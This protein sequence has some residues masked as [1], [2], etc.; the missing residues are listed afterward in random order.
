MIDL[1]KP[2]IVEGSEREMLLQIRSYLYQMSEQLQNAFVALQGGAGGGNYFAMAGRSTSSKNGS[3]SKEKSPQQ[4][5][6][7]LKALIIN[8]ADIVNAYS[9]KI[10]KILNGKYFAD[11]D[12]G[13]FVAQTSLAISANSEGILLQQSTIEEI[14]STVD[15][16]EDFKSSFEGYVKVGKFEDEGD[17]AMG[18]EVGQSNDAETTMRSR[19]TAQRLVFLGADGKEL[20]YFKGNFLYLSGSMQIDG[21][22]RMRKYTID[23]SYG[24]SVKYNG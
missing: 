11:S 20:G 23:N 5:F 13:T 15:G 14:L 3:E 19:F 7:E 4:S 17:D 6:N 1:I 22:L 12:F 9:D 16:F 2:H 8:S 24:L 18:V 10:D 21:D